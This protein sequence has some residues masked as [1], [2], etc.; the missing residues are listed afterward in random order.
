M[1]DQ[2]RSIKMSSIYEN[3][4]KFQNIHDFGIVLMSGRS[5]SPQL[6]SGG[7][8]FYSCRRCGRS[9]F[10]DNSGT[11]VTSTHCL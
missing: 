4:D 7:Q 3:A 9:V 1:T 5:A 8:Y 11:A 10:D 6:S 2:E